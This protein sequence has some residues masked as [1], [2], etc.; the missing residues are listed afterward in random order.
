MLSA[1]G[2]SAETFQNHMIMLAEN[3]DIQKVYNVRNDE[4][5]R[6]F[7]VNLGCYGDYHA[8]DPVE[9]LNGDVYLF[10]EGA[11]F[12]HNITF[13]LDLLRIHDDAEN[14]VF[15]E[16]IYSDEKSRHYIEVKFVERNE[17]WE[18]VD[19][20]ITKVKQAY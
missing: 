9:S 3:E 14:M 17:R 15:Y 19:V 6:V 8:D 13:T 5:F 11:I 20:A 18:L 16:F 12:F 1:Q 7:Y 2:I 10:N 4:G